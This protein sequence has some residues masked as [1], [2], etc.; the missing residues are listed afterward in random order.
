MLRRVVLLRTDVSEGCSASIICATRISELGTTLA[1]TS[2]RHTTFLRSI[3]LLL[4]IAN[5]VH[6]SPILVALMTEEL[7]SSET[8]DLIRS[9][10]PNITEDGILR[11]HCREGLKSYKW[12]LVNQKHLFPKQNVKNESCFLKVYSWMT[13]LMMMT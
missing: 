4:V 5:V 8:S 10:R 13:N 11:S 7:P 3:R 2:N 6:S 1:V 12:C 9:T